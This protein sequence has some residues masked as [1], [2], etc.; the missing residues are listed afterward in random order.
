MAIYSCTVKA[1]SRSRGESATGGAAYRLGLAI[2]DQRTGLKHDYSKRADVAASFT[3]LPANAPEGWDDPSTLWNEVERSEKRIN[4]CIGRECLVALPAEMTDDQR[5]ELARAIAQQLVEKH[6]VATS[7]GIHRPQEEGDLNY[8]AHIMFSDRR[9]GAD[10]FGEKTREFNGKEGPLTVEAIRLMVAEQTNSHLQRHGYEARVDHRSLADQ[11]QEALELGD[12]IKAIELSR[13]PTQHAG[14]APEVRERVLE[15]N[16][17]IRAENSTRL[18]EDLAAFDRVLD[19]A[20]ADG[21][22]MAP[23]S[24]TRVSPEEQKRREKEIR[25]HYELREARNAA[26]EAKEKLLAAKDQCECVKAEKDLAKAMMEAETSCGKVIDMQLAKEL[27]KVKKAEDFRTDWEKNNRLRKLLGWEP[28]QLK[29]A[30]ASALKHKEE[31][32]Q[33]ALEK[34]EIVAAQDKLR[35]RMA[36]L[37]TREQRVKQELS[38]AVVNEQ[39]AREHWKAVGDRQRFYRQS[40]EVVNSK[41]DRAMEQGHEDYMR[42]PIQQQQ[43]QRQQPQQEQD[44]GWSMSM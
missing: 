21:R 11:K 39:Q 10:G 31:A 30:D 9:L 36:S 1:F 13:K 3:L 15:A 34:A 2:E 23:A 14:R 38:V 16:E 27:A 19:A 35:D 41:L 25:D 22:A 32:E 29:A 12:N 6:G 33:K 37:E 4:S 24:D 5:E 20:I 26:D 18:L 44:K 7:T 17:A 28:K 8:H 40:Q 43:P 42:P